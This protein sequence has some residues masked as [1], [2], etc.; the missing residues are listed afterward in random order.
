VTNLFNNAAFYSVGPA[1][2]LINGQTGLGT[3]SALIGQPRDLRTF[4][5]RAGFN[6]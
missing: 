1:A 2:A 3:Y 5:V 6:F 4:G